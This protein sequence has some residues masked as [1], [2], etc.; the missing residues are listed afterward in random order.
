L[1]VVQ[2]EAFGQPYP[3][4]SLPKAPKSDF[5]AVFGSLA[6]QTLHNFNPLVPSA[7]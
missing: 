3:K 4:N 1:G 7:D 6:S 5:N 2:K